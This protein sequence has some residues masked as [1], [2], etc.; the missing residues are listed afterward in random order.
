MEMRILRRCVGDGMPALVAAWQGPV[1]RDQ[2]N[3]GGAAVR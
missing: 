3:L 1:A 2:V